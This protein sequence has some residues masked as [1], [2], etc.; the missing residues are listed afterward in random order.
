MAFDAF[1]SISSI[2]GESND[3]RHK[4]WI[5]VLAYGLGAR[6]RIIKAPSSC[7]G[8][9]AGR[10]DFLNLVFKKEIDASTPLLSLACAQG[11]H[12]DKVV[13]D[14]CRAAGDKM[15]FM[16]YRFH[17]CIIRL[18]STLGNQYQNWDLVWI[19]F[20]KVFWDY[21]PINRT[22][23]GPMGHI[24]AGWNRQTNSKV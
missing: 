4:G 14:I 3:D 17:N 5:E 16:Q 22:T 21:I 12:I 24:L 15:N 19:D 6:Q 8:A 2:E 9:C 1:I 20:R 13:L 18:V 7:G 23:G 10:A 11:R